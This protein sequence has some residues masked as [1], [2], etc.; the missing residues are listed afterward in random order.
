MLQM[1]YSRTAA[2]AVAAAA[3]AVAVDMSD[4]PTDEIRTM[5]TDFCETLAGHLTSVDSIQAVCTR[6]PGDRH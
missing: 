2:A 4:R 1:R 3:A 5:S 6:T